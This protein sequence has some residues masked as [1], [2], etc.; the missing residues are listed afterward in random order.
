MHAQASTY[1]NRS[2]LWVLPDGMYGKYTHTANPIFIHLFG[3]SWHGS[4]A[5]SVL[6]FV[7]HPAFLF[8][9]GAVLSLAFGCSLWLSWRKRKR[10]QAG[11]T[12]VTELVVDPVKSA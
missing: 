11:Y 1:R 7:K 3:S 4:D 6:W 12:R 9:S 2:A 5:R 8:A 10:R